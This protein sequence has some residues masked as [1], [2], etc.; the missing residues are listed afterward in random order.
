MLNFGACLAKGISGGLLI[1]LHGD[2]GAGKTTTVRGFMRALG[3]EGTVK[4]PTYTLV[5]TYPL[6]NLQIYHFDLYRLSDPEELE[7]IGGREFFQDDTISLIE[8]PENGKGFLPPQ[9]M[10]VQI[11]YVDEDNR[12]VVLQANTE[13]GGRVMTAI[14]TAY[15]LK[16]A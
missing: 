1:F 16:S 4:S 2:L 7:Y 8:W 5:E 6:A 12:R 9:D 15:G 3:H 14:N 11:F 10:D 13:R